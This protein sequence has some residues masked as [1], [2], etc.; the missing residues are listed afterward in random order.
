MSA[1]FI[2]YFYSNFYND[3]SISHSQRNALITSNMSFP[4]AATCQDLI[5]QI[6]L[7]NSYNISV[8]QSTSEKGLSIP[9]PIMMRSVSLTTINHI[10]HS[11]IFDC[12]ACVAGSQ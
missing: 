4:C 9:Q 3:K 10:E 1:L 12:H 7:K 8:K 2:G 6:S 11:G 5:S